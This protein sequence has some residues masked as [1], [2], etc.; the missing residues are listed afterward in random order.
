MKLAALQALVMA[1]EEGSLRGAAR[2]L[3]M[4]QPALSKMVRE[5]E[6]E[7]SAPLLQR[8]SRGVEPTAEGKVLYGRA[9]RACRE[10]DAAVEE[11]GQLGGQMVG[12]LHI[13]AVPLAVMLLIP[14]M[15]RTFV[16]RFPD[17]RLRISEA[18]Y[19]A[20][21][22]QLRTGEMDIIIG[23]IP[24]DLSLGE[25]HTEPLL[26]TCMVP[27]ARLGSAWLAA[28]SLAELQAAP[29]VYTGAEFGVGYARV[30]YEQHGLS[31]P[32]RGATVN[33]TLGLLS[34]VSASDYVALMPQ[35]IVSLPPFS[36]QMAVIPVRE[37][38]LPLRVGAILR[39]E[40]VL[41]PLMRQ[42]LAHLHR[43]A[44]HIAQQ[45]AG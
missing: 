38:G 32:P 17:I 12:S 16:P 44:H 37:Q 40:S 13:G 22:Q 21:L 28:A 23:G 35:Q 2:R 43:A 9:L 42:L 34:L 4:S 5:L 19:V 33:S 7:L 24:D 14:E 26:T 29:W 8:S 31:A 41:Q 30:L 36:Q 39:P 45:A 15:L 1:V 3:Q 25:F 10:L 11:I 6:L 27:A 20:Q 18:L